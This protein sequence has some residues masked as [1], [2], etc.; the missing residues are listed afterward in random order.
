MKYQMRFEELIELGYENESLDF[1]ATQYKNKEALIKDVMSF[2]NSSSVGEKH[3]LLGVKEKADGSK[4]IIGIVSSEFQDSAEIQQLIHNNIEPEVNI[5]YMPFYYSEKLLGAIVIRDAQDKPYMMKKKYGKMDRGLCYVRKG[6]TQHIATRVD[7]DKFY[8][9]RSQF[10][11]DILDPF[12]YT[13][14]KR[15]AADTKLIFRNHTTNPVTVMHGKLELLDSEKEVLSVHYL[16]GFGDQIQG[17]EFSLEIAPKKE[18]VDYGWFTFTSTDCLRIGCDEDGVTNQIRY[19]KLTIIDSDENSYV[20]I[21][22]SYSVLAKGELLW[23][24]KL[25][26]GK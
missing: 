6:S 8:K 10:K 21:K 9:S 3:I 22:E 16:I 11:F 13:N 18:L 23:K 2:A 1:K 20:L 25:K 24:V 4:E 15:S 26:S 14:D 7:Y 5:E 17:A 19:A 12:L